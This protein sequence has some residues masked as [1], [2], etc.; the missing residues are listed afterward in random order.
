MV[1]ANPMYF[2]IPARPPV[3]K[4]SGDAG[5]LVVVIAF[6]ILIAVFAAIVPNANALPAA[7]CS[8]T[9]D[10]IAFAKSIDALKRSCLD[11]CTAFSALILLFALSRAI[12]ATT[13]PSFFL[14]AM[15]SSLA[16]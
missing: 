9:N 10:P 12:A 13:S 14:L 2:A 1:A 6:E 15:N 4:L 7:V 5:E 16:F 8:P 3:A 11:C